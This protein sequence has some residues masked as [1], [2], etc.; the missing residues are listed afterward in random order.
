MPD[1]K[2]QYAFKV[3]PE[4]FTPPLRIDFLERI[5]PAL[6][7]TQIA[8]M[9]GVRHPNTFLMRMKRGSVMGNT[10]DHK[11]FSQDAGDILN[12]MFW[13]LGV[14]LGH[15]PDDPQKTFNHFRKKK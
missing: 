13:V 5:A 10:P 2:N 6:N 1:P 9:T 14:G 7:I 11:Q 3:R 8:R 4:I 15:F 12:E